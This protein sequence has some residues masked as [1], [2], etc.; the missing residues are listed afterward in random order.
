MSK[1]EYN[2]IL[3]IRTGAIGDVVHTTNLVHS[4]KKENCSAQIH[5]MTSKTIIPLIANDSA[6]DKVIIINPKFKQLCV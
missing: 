6:I 1:K 5:Y 3:I 2:K 4:I